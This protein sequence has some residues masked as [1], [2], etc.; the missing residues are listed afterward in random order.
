MVV[1]MFCSTH[2][3]N[4]LS[5]NQSSTNKPTNLICI[6]KKKK[7]NFKLILILIHIFRQTFLFLLFYF[8]HVLSKFEFCS[9]SWCLLLQNPCGAIPF[10]LVEGVNTF[11][12]FSY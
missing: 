12:S 5:I 9:I 1:G 2:E 11:S 3:T 10:I 6:Y 4:S 8:L 7:Q